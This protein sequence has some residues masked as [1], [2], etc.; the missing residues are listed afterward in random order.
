MGGERFFGWYGSTCGVG[1][2][3]ATR[4]CSPPQCWNRGG[5]SI[6]SHRNNMPSLSSDYTHRSTAGELTWRTQNAP[7]LLVAGASSRTP[8]RKLTALPNPYLYLVPYRP[9]ELHPGSVL[10]ASSSSSPRDVD[11]VPMTLL[12]NRKVQKM[13]AL[14]AANDGV[15][16]TYYVNIIH[17]LLCGLPRDCIKRCIVCP[18][19]TSHF[20]K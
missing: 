3:G 5:E 8:L 4:A 20:S 2:A 18:F 14:H 9:Q 1:T 16:C 15:K 19:R 13:C 17:P 11:F 7:K 6:F 12:N 10:W